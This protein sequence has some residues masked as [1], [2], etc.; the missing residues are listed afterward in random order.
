MEPPHP[1]PSGNDPTVTLA[2]ALEV[3]KSQP[4][5]PTIG[6]VLV[7]MSGGIDSSVAAALLHRAGLDV[8]GVSMRLFEKAEARSK[9]DSEGRCCS[10]DDFHDARKVAQDLGF[11]HFVLDF[12]ERFNQEV[13]QAF[14]SSYLNG[15]TPNP[16]INCNKSLKFDS[17]IKRAAALSASHVATGHY[18]RIHPRSDGFALLRGVDP[19]KDQSY[20]LYHLNQNS[21]Q[22]LLFP[23]GGYSKAQ[24]RDLARQMELHLADK[25]ESQEICFIT[26]G[27][28]DQFLAESGAVD[29]DRPG[30][31]RHLDGTLLGIH[32]GYWKFTVGQRKGLG[33]ASA[34]PLY[35][36][37]IEP[38]TN[39]VWAGGVR[40]LDR[41]TLTAG[42]VNWCRT[43]PSGPFV[44]EARIRSRSAPAEALVVPAG[45]DRCEVTF[46]EP[47]RAIAPGQAVVFYR[48]DEVLGG[49]WIEAD[50]RQLPS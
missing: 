38:S 35:V 26:E 27:R 44:C 49:G 5:F 1:K 6:R 36:I 10:L 24:I 48:D 3:L 8:V 47:Q 7:A 16:C 37:R 30:E 45:P 15:F 20:F 12:E 29:G 23:L 22:K 34:D 43:V 32:P 40:D 28:Y 17:L 39:T 4:A 13:I 41:K 33:I 46:M 9:A 2:G 14:T 25:A 18:A 42:E 19:E 50:R 21:M 31:I 11:S